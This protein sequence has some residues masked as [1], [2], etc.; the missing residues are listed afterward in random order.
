MT[1]QHFF[2]F[3][4]LKK[5]ANNLDWDAMPKNL[6][7]DSKEIYLYNYKLPDENLK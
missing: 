7:D 1:R 2:D 4:Q 6:F 3:E 5:V